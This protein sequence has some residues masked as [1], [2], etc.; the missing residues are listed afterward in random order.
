MREIPVWIKYGETGKVKGAK[1]LYRPWE[2]GSFGGGFAVFRGKRGWNQWSL[3]EF[4][5]KGGVCQEGGS[6]E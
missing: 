5:G 6:L 2:G 3:T 1:F 4:L